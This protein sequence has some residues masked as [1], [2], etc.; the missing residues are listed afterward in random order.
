MLLAPL[1]IAGCTPSRP[2]GSDLIERQ[3]R[4]EAFA[5]QA[6]VRVRP[7]EG[8]PVQISVGVWRGRSGALRALVTKADVDVLALRLD[9][10]GTLRVWSPRQRETSLVTLSDPDLPLLVAHLPLVV[11][12]LVNGPLPT[13][14]QPGPDGTWTT[15]VGS[16]AVTVTTQ[17]DRPVTKTVA[18]GQGT[19]LLTIT[20]GEMASFDGVLRPRRLTV[21]A[22]GGEAL[23]LLRRFDALGDVSAEGLRLEIPDDADTVP[24]P[25]LLDHV[26]R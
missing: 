4:A 14:A 25:L 18:D 8:E 3:G 11:E 20:Y 9:P 10:E 19:T 1:L 15:T 21:T 22:P 6:L 13:G 24:L 17:G 5:A 2:A 16:L 7:T 26:N 23:I 12:D